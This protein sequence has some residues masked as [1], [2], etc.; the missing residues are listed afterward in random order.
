VSPRLLDAAVLA[1]L[2]ALKFHI[3]GQ[4][5]DWSYDGGYYANIAEHVRDG[6]GFVTDI[7]MYHQGLPSY[8]YPSPVYPLWPL[9]LGVVAKVV[10]MS[11][12]AVW[13]PSLFYLGTVWL[14]G[15]LARSVDDRPLV[16]DVPALR[17]S[18]VVMLLVALNDRFL[19]YT[20]RPYTEGMAWFLL[21]ATLPRVVEGFR[22]PGFVRG[23][24]VGVWC[25]LWVG[26]RGPMIVQAGTVV[27]AMVALLVFGRE[28]QGMALAVLG[29]GASAAVAAIALRA[30]Y[31]DVPGATLST[32]VRFDNWVVVPGLSQA[33]LL[34][35][36]AS[37]SERLATLVQG[38]R[39]AYD[40]QSEFSYRKNFGYLQ[41]ALPVA[42]V[43]VAVRAWRSGPRA[44]RDWLL[45]RPML[46]LLVLL[47][48]G[49]FA[50]MHAIHKALFSEW[51]FGM[52]QALG[53]WMLFIPCGLL[54]LR[55]R[56]WLR[57]I[58]AVLV[59]ST[60]MR[61]GSEAQR[62]RLSVA[63]KVEEQAA[64][65]GAIA[66]IERLRRPGE[67]LWIGTTYPQQLAVWGSDV[68]WIAAL[69]WST[70][71]D[72]D[73]MV[74]RDGLRALLLR[75]DLDLEQ[76]PFLAD[77]AALDTRWQ[78]VPDPPPGYRA[79]LPREAAR[80]R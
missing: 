41:Y 13:L 74:R 40:P 30:W 57:V 2:V 14:A 4:Q 23:V 42:A 44:C 25:A 19:E 35:A 59:A 65:E 11:V 76:F 9:L 24:E 21:V 33:A 58:G 43:V 37:L 73:L 51:N 49:Q 70:L 55:S 52:R 31:A 78:S 69:E 68:G 29:L 64:R 56:G 17:P 36:P 61:N 71:D 5:V 1:G 20:S 50:A 26:V 79:W 32:L 47:G 66:W 48:L 6:D 18:A 72:L 15:R 28:R 38:F 54:L 8:P 75:E 63:L 12:A 16:R 10:P 60:L 34:E 62:S 45:E 39:E 3:N 27:A 80:V 7:S 77:P 46:T 53:E 67:P 22:S